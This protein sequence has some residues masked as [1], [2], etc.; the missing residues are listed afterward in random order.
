VP[1][2]TPSAER[3]AQKGLTL[4]V[5]APLCFPVLDA[6]ALELVPVAP[7]ALAMPMGA[8]SVVAGAVPAALVALTYAELAAAAS[9]CVFN[10]T[11]PMMCTTPFWRRMSG[12]TMCALAVPDMTKGVVPLTIAETLEPAA[13]VRAP[14]V[15]IPE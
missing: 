1:T 4:I 15:S 13:E 11:F 14:W 8:V 5:V 10:S 9:V 12:V 6:L 7:L 3:A 2:T